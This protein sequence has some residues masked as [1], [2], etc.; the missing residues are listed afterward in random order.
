[1]KNIAF[2]I[3]ILS[4][5]IIWCQNNEIEKLKN[6]ESYTIRDFECEGSTCYTIKKYHLNNGLTSVYEKHLL[7]K[8]FHRSVFK[9]WFLKRRV[10]FFKAAYEYDSNENII[11]E[12][13]YDKKNDTI[14]KIY[15]YQPIYNNKEFLIQRTVHGVTENYS[16]FTT[17]GRPKLIIRKSEGYDK[18]RT[19]GPYKVEQ[20]YDVN[21]NII[22][23]MFYYRDEIEIIRNT[24]DSHN[25]IIEIQR[26][27]QPERNFPVFI[28]RAHYN[29]GSQFLYACEKYRYVYNE[30]GL[31]TKKYKIINGKEELIKKRRFKKRRTTKPKLH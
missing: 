24:F 8:L 18:L 26:E 21:D 16:D 9:S 29:G 22:K 13:V 19:Q 15:D 25:N 4:T 17:L 10:S 27:F 11:R 30:D 12:I 1:M 20:E 6:Y 23:T 5:S 2:I 28:F 3:L 7:K 14:E 31:W